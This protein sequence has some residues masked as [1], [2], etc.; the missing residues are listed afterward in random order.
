M[1]AATPSTTRKTI[2]HADHGA[3]GQFTSWAFT[4]NVRNYKLKLS[5]ETV[6]DCFDNAID[7]NRSG[8]E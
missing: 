3:Q 5:P 6:G 2:I 7:A 4:S 8:E 1:A